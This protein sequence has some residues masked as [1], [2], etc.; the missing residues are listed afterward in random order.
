MEHIFVRV[1]LEQPVG[2]VTLAAVRSVANR[3]GMMQCTL[4]KMLN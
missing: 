4:C 2:I 1:V 3:D